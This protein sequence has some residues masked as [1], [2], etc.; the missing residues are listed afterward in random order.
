MTSIDNN[1][2]K[3]AI[4]S[5]WG[6]SIPWYVDLNGKMD[7]VCKDRR[8][9]PFDQREKVPEY[10]IVSPEWPLVKVTEEWPSVVVENSWSKK[11]NNLRKKFLAENCSL[12]KTYGGDKHKWLLYKVNNE[13]TNYKVR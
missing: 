5:G 6:W 13:N 12:L 10:F 8:A 7:R 2:E 4:F 1:T 9:F 3:D 11:Q